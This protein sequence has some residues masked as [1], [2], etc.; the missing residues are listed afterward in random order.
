MLKKAV[1]KAAA[2]EEARRTL[3]YV[4]PL[5]DARTKLANFFSIL[6]HDNAAACMNILPRQPPRLF[7]DDERHHIG[8]I[9]GETKP[10]QR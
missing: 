7:T 10:L 3:R 5:S 2:S 4:E 6:L 1:S 9:L 8:N